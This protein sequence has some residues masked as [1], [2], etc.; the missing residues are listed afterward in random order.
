MIS[1]RLTI[2]SLLSILAIPAYVHPQTGGNQNIEGDERSLR[3]AIR[4]IESTPDALLGDDFKYI[5]KR[6]DLNGDGRSEVVVWIPEADMGGTSGYPILVLSRTKTG[7]RKLLDIDQGWTPV[8][9]LKT[10]HGQ[11]RDIAYQVA[12]GGA[13]PRYFIYGNND[14]IYRFRRAQIKRPAG[15]SIIQK[16]WNQTTFGPIPKQ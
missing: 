1:R 7:Y 12:G 3:E 9:V 2:L 16:D 10:K 6:V 4:Q 15:E 13:R 14:S 5:A 11:W 8:I